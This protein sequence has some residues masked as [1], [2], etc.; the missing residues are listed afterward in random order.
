VSHCYRRPPL[1]GFPYNLFA[2]VHG[3]S[4]D[5]VRKTVAEMASRVGLKEYDVLFSTTEFKKVSM[6]YFLESQAP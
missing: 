1:E 4:E 2:M 6:R 3:H 5:E